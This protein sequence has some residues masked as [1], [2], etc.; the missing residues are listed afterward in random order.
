MLEKASLIKKTGLYEYD[1]TLVRIIDADTIEA[2]IV[3]GFYVT[4]RAKVRLLGINAPEKNTDS[5]KEAIKWLTDYLPIGHEIT[6][7]VFKT[8]ERY[9]RWLAT[10]TYNGANVNEELIKSG[11]AVPYWGGKR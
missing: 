6:L 8:P 5:G 4:Y 7:D 2:D 9:G 3:L 1:A 11:N 10:V